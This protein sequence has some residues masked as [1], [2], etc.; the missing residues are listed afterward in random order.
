MRVLLN[1]EERE[2]KLV[3]N[4]TLHDVVTQIETTLPQGHLIAEVELNDKIL[5]SSWYHNAAKIYLLDDDSLSIRTEDAAVIGGQALSISKSTLQLLLIDFEKIADSFRTQ[6]ATEANT[7]FVEGIE[8][9][10]LYLKLLEDSVFMLGRPLAN[11]KD[12]EGAFM[13]HIDSLSAKLDTII[14]IQDQKD[15][16]MLADMIEYEMLPALTKIGDIYQILE[17]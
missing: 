8:N 7:L 14:Q 1:E 9:L 4:G 11:I 5:D 6:D 15:W 3:S 17:D 10:Q 13:R 12:S 2:I 16:V